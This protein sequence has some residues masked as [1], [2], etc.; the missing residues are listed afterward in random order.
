V[1]DQVKE[2][3]HSDRGQLAREQIV[4]TFP[5]ELRRQ[6]LLAAIEGVMNP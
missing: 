6:A 2:A 4:R 5:L 1:A 3:L